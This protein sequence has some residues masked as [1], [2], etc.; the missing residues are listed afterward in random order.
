MFR[1]QFIYAKGHIVY[2]T[3]ATLMMFIEK[4]KDYQR[5]LAWRVFEWSMQI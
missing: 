1:K 5:Y 2:N 3:G 4:A